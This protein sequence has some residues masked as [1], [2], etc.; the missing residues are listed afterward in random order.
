MKKTMLNKAQKLILG[1]F[2]LLLVDI[3]WVSSSELTKYLYQNE[4]FDKPFFCTYFKTS[5]FTI[6]LMI[7]GVITPWKE[8]CPRNS[9]YTLVDPAAAEDEDTFY[10]NGTS[11]LSDSS[12]IP[13]KATDQTVSGTE[14]DDSSIRSVR[15]SKLAEV[16]EMSP[17]EATEALMSRLSYSASLRVRRQKSHHKTART[18]LMFCILWFIANYMFQLAL[19]P[20]SETAM[21]TLLSSTSSFFTLILAAIFPSAN[22]DKFTLSKFMAVIL[23]I[24]GSTMV[25]VSEIHEPKMSRGIVLALMSAFFYASYLVLVKR[26]SDTEEKIDIPLFFGF[27]GLWSLLLMWPL[28]FVLNFSQLEPFELPSRRQFVV[29]FLNGLIGTVFSEAL[30]LWGCFLTSTLIGTIAMSLQIPIAMIFDLILHGKTYPIIFYLGSIPMFLSLIFI[31]FLIKYDDTDPILK[32]FKIIYRKLWF[33][34]R[35][36][37]IVRISTDLESEQH[38]SLIDNHEN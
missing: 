3:I 7:L 31:A 22:G 11:N 27:V 38:E 4:N 16:R 20:P 24:T 18:A 26:K 5:M 13:I 30:W 25:S 34:H 32:Y 36:G 37:T 15:F 1:I 14:S 19:E 8:A 28:L 33:C 10:A 2:L 29:L 17:H 23:S 6:Y 12:F 21:I 9:N 35:T